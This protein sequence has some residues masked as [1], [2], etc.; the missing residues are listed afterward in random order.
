MFGSIYRLAIVLLVVGLSVS[1]PPSFSSSAS[2]HFG[3]LLHPLLPHTHGDG[4]ADASVTASP[5][6]AAA[7]QLDLD[8][9]PG[10]RGQPVE[11]GFRSGVG[12]MLVPL[13]LAGLLLDAR[14]LRHTLLAV[15]HQ[16]RRAPLAPPPRLLPPLHI[17]G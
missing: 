1:V 11:D 12:G 3:L 17:V 7:G 8:Q 15:P 10:L 6:G 9:Q 5:D 13:L 4:H 2:D 16:D 14:R